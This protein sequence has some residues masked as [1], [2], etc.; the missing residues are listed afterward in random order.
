MYERAYLQLVLIK[1]GKETTFITHV[2]THPTREGLTE[3]L[4]KLAKDIDEHLKGEK[5]LYWKIMS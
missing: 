1:D 3:I 4:T 2:F 5:T